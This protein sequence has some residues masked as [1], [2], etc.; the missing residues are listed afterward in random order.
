[1]D[2]SSCFD[3]LDLEGLPPALGLLAPLLAVSAPALV[4]DSFPLSTIPQIN[5]PQFFLRFLSDL[6]AAV[7]LIAPPCP[8]FVGPQPRHHLD[9][10]CQAW[11]GL[12]SVIRLVLFLRPQEP[13][14]FH[15]LLVGVAVMHF[16]CAPPHSRLV[17]QHR[18]MPE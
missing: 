8:F 11:L 7:R 14:I 12:L 10:E 5:D 1:M 16:G 3:Q 15:W 18:A 17:A 13:L 2:L 6:C 4:I 9:Q